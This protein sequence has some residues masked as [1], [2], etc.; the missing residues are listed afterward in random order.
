MAAQLSRRNRSISRAETIHEIRNAWVSVP[1][2]PILG[3]LRNLKKWKYK[4]SQRHFALPSFHISD[5]Y[6]YSYVYY[7]EGDASKFPSCGDG[8]EK[9]GDL[10]RCGKV[11]TCGSLRISPLSAFDNTVGDS[12][13]LFVTLSKTGA[14]K[15]VVKYY[16]QAAEH[17]RWEI[18]SPRNTLKSLLLFV[19][20]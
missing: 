7:R 18:Q 19:V 1:V 11:V 3:H 4:M 5:E 9:A 2:L 17:W 15:Y 10:N 8:V 6:A 20:F 13:M 16:A 12:K 14:P